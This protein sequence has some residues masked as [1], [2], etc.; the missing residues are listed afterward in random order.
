MEAMG[1]RK[2]RAMFCEARFYL[3][4]NNRRPCQCSTDEHI[5]KTNTL[6]ESLSSLR[7]PLL[8]DCFSIDDSGALIPLVES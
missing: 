3:Q 5:H 4:G 8:W 7:E 1:L 2:I 6:S